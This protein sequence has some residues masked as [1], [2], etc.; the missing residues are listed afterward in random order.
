MG[1]IRFCRQ[2]IPHMKRR[3][4]GR[5]VNVT[6]VGGKAPAPRS[7]PTS[8]S[9][10]AGIN[11]TKSLAHEYAADK[12]L[13]NTIC[14]G[15]VRERPDRPPRQGRRS[16]GPLPRAGQ[17]HPH[18]PGRPRRRVRRP[19]GLPRLRSRR[20][21]HRHR[22]QLRRRHGR[23]RLARTGRDA[24]PQPSGAPRRPP[25]GRAQAQRLQARRG[26]GGRSRA[27]RG[28]RPQHLHVGGSLHARAHERPPL[29]RE[30]LGGGR[31]RGR[32]RGG[33]GGEVQRS[34]SSSRATSCRACS[35]GASTSC[36]P[37]RG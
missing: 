21:H 29:L 36:P 2:V 19:R 24:D 37:A 15:L 25:V 18:R 10:A 9:R 23:R 34:R 20:L 5:I 13:V 11:L 32:P 27:R 12:I 26:L 16:R 6:T 17:A 28:A 1:A 22:H 14:I 33:P 8:V 30:A 31:A 7:L 3:G 4:G 35:A